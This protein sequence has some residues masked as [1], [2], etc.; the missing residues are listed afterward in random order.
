MIVDG[1][2]HA[3]G[4]FADVEKLVEELDRCGVDKVA[5]CPG[6]KNNTKVWPTPN[7]PISAV[8]RHPL[9]SRYFIRWGIRFSYNFVF[10]DKGD[11]NE[12]VHSFVERHPDRVVQVYWVDPRK[13]DFMNKLANDLQRWD[14]KGIKLHQACTPFKN[15]GPE[16]SQIAKFAGEKQLPL[17]I[18]LWSDDEA[19]KLV[20]LANSH[21]DTDF[22]LLHLIALEVVVEHTCSPRN[23]YCDISPYAYVSEKQ[24]ASAVDAFGA[25]HVIFGS[26]TPFDKNSLERG[27]ERVRSMALSA[28]QKE[29]I[30][31]GNIADL[32]KLQF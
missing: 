5:L 24:I 6:L 11:G 13:P 21:P 22:V 8:K 15:D 1:H 14:F 12:F 20:A 7:I 32:L 9:Y 23:I 28:I 16:V 18:H 3:A 25:D 30:L 31:G 10:K 26:D 2:A 19:R 29:R 4:E 27:M 17:F